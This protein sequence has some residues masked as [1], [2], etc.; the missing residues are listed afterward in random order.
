MEFLIRI[1]AAIERLFSPEWDK[2]HCRICTL[3]EKLEESRR[4]LSAAEL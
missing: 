2:N 3:A 4:R 1:W